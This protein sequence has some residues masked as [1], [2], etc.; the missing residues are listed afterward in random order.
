[1]RDHREDKEANTRM[2]RSSNERCSV[3]GHSSVMGRKHRDEKELKGNHPE[4]LPNIRGARDDQF[5]VNLQGTEE[6]QADK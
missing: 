1:M 4:A 6:H 5:E 3:C 2:L